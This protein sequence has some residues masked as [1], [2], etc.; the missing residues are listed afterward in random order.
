MENSAN[1]WNECMI[2]A[3]GFKLFNNDQMVIITWYFW[4]F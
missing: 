3:N 1:R 2:I 4:S